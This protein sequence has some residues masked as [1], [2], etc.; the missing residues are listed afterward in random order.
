LLMDSSTAPEAAF[1][2]DSGHHLAERLVWHE[3]T[4]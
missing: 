1:R 4:A 2:H 3:F